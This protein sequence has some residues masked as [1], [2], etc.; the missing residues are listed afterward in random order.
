MAAALA[1]PLLRRRALSAAIRLP[2]P[3]QALAELALSE[4]GA[5]RQETY[6][7]LRLSRRTHLADSLVPRVHERH[8]GQEAAYLLTACS[9]CC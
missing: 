5:V 1:D 6:R 3:E 4:V 8:G 9:Q 2:V 7:V